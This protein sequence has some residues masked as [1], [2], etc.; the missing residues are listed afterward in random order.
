MSSL[1]LAFISGSTISYRPD[2]S[3][4]AVPTRGGAAGVGGA[5]VDGVGVE[6]LGVGG[7][8]PDTDGGALEGLLILSALI[9]E[10]KCARQTAVWDPPANLHTRH[11]GPNFKILSKVMQALRVGAEVMPSIDAKGRSRGSTVSS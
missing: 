7:S 5:G 6:G 3:E 11:D 1:I 4:A 10:L 8:S 2:S 9:S